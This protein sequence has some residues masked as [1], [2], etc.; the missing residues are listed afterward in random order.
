MAR[1][2]WFSRRGDR[3]RHLPAAT[4]T[5]WAIISA[6][7]APSAANRFDPVF[8]PTRTCWRM[9]N[10][11][12]KMIHLICIE[13]SQLGWMEPRTQRCRAMAA[14]RPISFFDFLFF[15]N[16]KIKSNIK[17]KKKVKRFLSVLEPFRPEANNKTRRRRRRRR[18]RK[19]SRAAGKTAVVFPG[20]MSQIIESLFFSPNKEEEM[21]NFF[22]LKSKIIINK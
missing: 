19:W 1:L 10:E 6:K 18:R 21:L 8:Q 11:Q 15:H 2:E 14:S 16:K 13:N 5:D 20:E 9:T 3:G 12:A 7:M 4:G 22:Y 17:I